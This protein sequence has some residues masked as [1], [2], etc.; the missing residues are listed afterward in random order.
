[1]DDDRRAEILKT[2]SFILDV[3]GWSTVEQQEECKYSF[4][5]VLVFIPI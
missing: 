4:V 3:F 2:V 5:W 1:V